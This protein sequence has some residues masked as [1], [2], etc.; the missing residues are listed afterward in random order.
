MVSSNSIAALSSTILLS[1]LLSFSVSSQVNAQVNSQTPQSPS[2]RPIETTGTAK[3]LATTPKTIAV[4]QPRL[5]V[6]TTTAGSGYNQAIDLG[7]FTPLRQTPGQNLTYLDGRLKIDTSSGVLGGNLL[8]GHRFVDETQSKIIGGYVSYDTRNTGN[9]VFNQLGAGFDVLGRNWDFH[10]NAY[11]P[12]GQNN[13][14]LGATSAIASGFQGNSLVLDRTRV[15]Q[16]ALAGFD[17]EVGRKLMTWNGGGLKGYVGGYLYSGEGI[18]SF[19]GVRSRLVGTWNG[20]TTGLSIQNDPRFDTRV[21]FNIGAT[22]GGGSSSR[23]AS[24]SKTDRTSIASRLGDTPQRESNILVDQ[25]IVRDTV[26]AINPATGQPWVF[27]QVTLGATGTGTAESPTGTVASAL[28]KTLTDGNGIVYVKSGTN[29]GIPAFTVPTQVQVLSTGSAQTLNT[30]LGMVNLPG[31]GTGINPTSATV[32]LASNGSNQV[33]SGFAITNSPNQPGIIGN[34][35]TNATIANNRVTIN[36]PNTATNQSLLLAGRGIVLIGANSTTSGQTLIDKNNVTNAIGEGIRLENIN[37]KAFIT[38]NTVLNTIQPYD[39]TGLEA[40]IYI[41]NNKGDV[42]LTIA[43][44][45]VG[46]NNTRSTTGYASVIG[47]GVYTK[48]ALVGNEVDGIEFSLCRSYAGGLPDTFAACSGTATA[49]VNIA[50]NTVRNIGQLGIDGADG[51]DMNLN[52]GDVDL[53]PD[54]GARISS[55]SITGNTVTNIADK[56]V[57]FGSDG[58]AVLGLGTVSNNTITNVG[59][60]GIALRARQTSNTNYVVTNN[61]ITK[62]A[63]NG[64]EFS[65]TRADNAAI[66]TALID[67]NTI[68][69]SGLFGINIRTR[70]NGQATAIV[71]NNT[72]NNSGLTTGNVV[73]IGVSAEEASKLKIKLDNNTITGNRTEGIAIGA[74]TTN[75]GGTAQVNAIVTNNRIVGNN[76][77]GTA[78]GAFTARA[79]SN[80]NLCLQLQKNTAGTTAPT[81]YFLNKATTGNSVFRIENSVLISNVGT[82]TPALPLPTTFT[83]VTNNTCAF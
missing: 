82:F 81:G 18:A 24:D 78:S 15:L 75:A 59:G 14:Q 66:S 12:I 61:V 34:N 67:N 37:G 4:F 51:I 56:G 35:N 39:Q 44:N 54:K 57:S 79:A 76:T 28:S 48:T 32:T 58:D 68:K 26:V 74:N 20:V 53:L 38:S 27:Q 73:G 2:S 23:A 42:D 10:T 19:A 25:Q 9:T 41:R 33:L 40:S 64:I 69:D 8:F 11:L 29:P 55:L 49:K 71:T 36:A 50:N 21:V 63:A 3:A 83:S 62:A 7:A 1:S 65:E 77:A 45:L 5:S 80:T 16:D 52:N 30:S 47:S 22:L 70:I 46:D 13:I 31:S 43:N 72:I 17:A 6:Y 60:I